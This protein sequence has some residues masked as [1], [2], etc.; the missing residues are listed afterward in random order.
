MNFHG[1]SNMGFNKTHVCHPCT[2]LAFS[3]LNVNGTEKGVMEPVVVLELEGE[4][5]LEMGGSVEPHV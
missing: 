5:G 3:Y 1:K 4:I 2:N